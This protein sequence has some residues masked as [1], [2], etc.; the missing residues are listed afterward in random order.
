M[1][2][3]VCQL[4]KCHSRGFRTVY[5]LYNLYVAEKEYKNMDFDVSI[6][7]PPYGKCGRLALKF[8][9]NSADRVRV[10]NGQIILVLPKSMKQGSAN[11]NKIDR[12]L[13]IVST[14]D[15]ANNDFL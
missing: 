8:L 1:R 9:N 13:E 12:D 14:K 3:R 5:M 6:G 15:C 11:Y 7:N 10:K 2:N 4:N